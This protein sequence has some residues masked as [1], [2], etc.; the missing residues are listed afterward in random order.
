MT[1]NADTYTYTTRDIVSLCG[2]PEAIAARS[3]ELEPD[4]ETRHIKARSVYKWHTLTIPESRWH[5][6]F[7]LCPKLSPMDLHLANE[8]VR[9]RITLLEEVA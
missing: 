4:D 8:V 7:D 9:G 2:G 3:R 6:L 1:Q 5:V